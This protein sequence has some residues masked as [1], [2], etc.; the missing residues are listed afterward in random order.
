MTLEKLATKDHRYEKHR[1]MAFLYKTVFVKLW[2]ITYSTLVVLRESCTLLISVMIMII[3]T[4]RQTLTPSVDTDGFAT[5]CCD[6]E[7]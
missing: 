3:I 5:T 4:R 7:L 2:N 1:Q 6:L